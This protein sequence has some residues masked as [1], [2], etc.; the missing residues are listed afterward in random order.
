MAQFA[1]DFREYRRG[2]KP[3]DWSAPHSAEAG[4]RVEGVA[5]EP[6]TR[7]FLSMNPGLAAAAATERTLKWDVVGSPADAEVLA[8]MRPTVRGNNGAA[9]F[10]GTLVLRG[11]GTAAA[12]NG[13]RA[14]LGPGVSQFRVDKIV[15]GTA[16][17]LGTP[18]KTFIVG[19]YYWVRFQ[20][21][22]TTVR[23]RTWAL[24]ETEPGSWD[25]SVTDSSLTSGWV[26]ARAGFADEAWECPYFAVG[27]DGSAAAAESAMPVGM[28]SWIKTLSDDVEVTARF[29]YFDPASAS[30]KSWWESTHARD[31]GPTDFPANVTMR[32]LLLDPGN[33]ASRVEADANLAGLVLP[34]R[35]SILL[36]NEPVTP[37]GA[38]PLDSWPEYS[39]VGRP[40]ELRIGR[41]WLTKP[42]ATSQG[43]L[44]PH[45]RF[46][47]L[48]AAIARTEPD[49]GQQRASLPLDGPARMLA[50]RLPGRRYI[51][52][53]TGFKAL[54]AS[55][56]V[57]I[58]SSGSYAVTSFAVYVRG[59]I[60]VAGIPGAGASWFSRRYLGGSEYQWSIMILGATH[61]TPNQVQFSCHAADNSLLVSL[62]HSAAMNDGLP[63]DYVF[64][65][66][67]QTRWY[68]MIDG[69]VVGSGVPTKS[70]KTAATAVELARVAPGMLVLDHRFEAYVPEEEARSRFAARLAPDVYS[71]SMHRCDDDSG[72]T[73]TDYAT[74]ANHGSAVGSAGVDWQWEPSYLGSADLAGVPMPISGGTVFHLPADPIDPTDEIFRFSDRAR[75]TGTALVTRAKGLTLATPANYSEPA[76]GAGCVDVVGASDQP[77]T[78]QLDPAA[79]TEDTRIHVPRL[80]R[81]ELISRGGASSKTCDRE[82]FD[83]LRTLLP[84]RGGFYFKEPPLVEEFLAL[85]GQMGAHYGL[86]RSGRI[87]TDTVLPPVNP[88]PYG[89]EPLLEFLGYPNRGVTFGPNAAWS[90]TQ[91]GSNP[92]FGLAA[93]IRP[94]RVPPLDRSAVLGTYF[95]TGQ[96]IV[97]Y[98]N[99]AAGYYLGIDGRNGDL[100]FG[101]PGIT[102]SG[103]H[104][105][106]C[107]MVWEAGAYYFVIGYQDANSRSITVIKGGTFGGP[108]AGAFYSPLVTS[109]SE[110]P[111]SGTLSVPTGAPL[112]IGHGPQGS[113]HGVIS[114]VVGSSVG[115][116]YTDFQGGT[117]NG[118]TPADPDIGADRWTQANVGAS[119]W[120]NTQYAIQ[121]TDGVGDTVACSKT[122]LVGIVEGARWCPR[123]TFD[124]RTIAVPQLPAVRRPV[125]AWRTEARYRQNHQPLVGANVA[126]GVSAADRVALGQAYLSEP[127]PSGDVQNNYL[128]SLDN[129]LLTPLTVDADAGAVAS[130]LRTRLATTRRLVDVDDWTRDAFMLH[131]GDEVLVYHPRFGLSSG[132]P[133]RVAALAAAL[134]KL[135]AE[136]KTWG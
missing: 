18:T 108:F 57:N 117:A 82:S 29:E 98:V 80:L 10:V 7:N 75:T 36:K 34:E 87:Y 61:A 69:V 54:S 43:V 13:Y 51:G 114:C 85:L 116:H 110:N 118:G 28:E 72:T 76:S 35:G 134:S 9:S 62:L 66:K 42:T 120:S 78:V 91:G 6:A 135:S 50:D 38:G 132:R 59:V 60:P 111:T 68:A 2:R 15:A 22:G 90:L 52:I 77:I 96:T 55:G 84:F 119:Q 23:A 56:Y 41:R 105:T 12:A 104:Y 49:V 81:D 124:F 94:S 4:I 17:V 26:G 107:P 126:A 63:H 133:M 44:S 14:I 92:W 97:D 129:V 106:A 70:V 47:L 19:A 123:M 58:P 95:P 65:I 86:D 45:R 64:A 11:G 53:Q 16:T 39:F 127:D 101:A 121:L 109:K 88:G 122:G 8:L 32:G 102:I 130:A 79:G 115:L 37:G 48:G 27:T 46:E 112:R 33:I 131:V 24:G 100:I 40:V 3:D 1:T 73:I 93:W 128:N 89:N 31:C 103:R 71:S 125:P 113:F 25:V 83:A 21:T 74:L 99:G 5:Q 30:I 20:V 136:I 67:D